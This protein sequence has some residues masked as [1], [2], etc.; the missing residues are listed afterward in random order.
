MNINDIINEI[1]K[2][3]DCDKKKVLD[4][5]IDDLGIVD[6]QTAMQLLSVN[7]SRIYQIMNKNNTMNLGKH[8]YL[9]LN[10]FFNE[11]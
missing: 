1:Y 11:K 7:R 6:V 8:K 9:M 2:L 3:S 5:C 4:N 10:V